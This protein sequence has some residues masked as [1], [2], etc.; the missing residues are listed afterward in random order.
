MDVI[1][2][3]FVELDENIR[4][5]EANERRFSTAKYMVNSMYL[6]MRNKF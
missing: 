1:C 6:N 5:R 2:F 3:V 4:A